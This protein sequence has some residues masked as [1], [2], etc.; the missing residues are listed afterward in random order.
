MD[1]IDFQQDTV[2]VEELNSLAVTQE[3][4][5]FAL[6]Q[7]NPSVLHGIAVEV[8][9]TRWEDISGLDNVKRALKEHVPCFVGHLTKFLKFDT[10]PSHG[11]LFYGPPGDGKLISIFFFYFDCYL[12]FDFR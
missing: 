3:N 11:F 7:S 4:F 6:N 10:A 12:I 1:D 2:D 8:P 5:L 9:I